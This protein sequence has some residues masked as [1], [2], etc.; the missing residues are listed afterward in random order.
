MGVGGTMRLL[1]ATT[2]ALVSAITASAQGGNAQSEIPDSVPV[3]DDVGEAAPSTW[4]EVQFERTTIRLPPGFVPSGRI[5]GLDHGG[6][7]WVRQSV[8]VRAING[9]WAFRSFEASAGTRCV[10]ERQGGQVLLIER[11]SRDGL[12]A[13]AWYPYPGLFPIFQASSSRSED[14]QLIRQ[15]LLS[16]S[17]SSA[18]APTRIRDVAKLIE[19]RTN[20]SETFPVFNYQ[21]LFVLGDVSLQDYNDATGVVRRELRVGEE[22]IEVIASQQLPLERKY[23]KDLIVRT[24][25][26]PCGKAVKTP[27]GT[28]IP[29]GGNSGRELVFERVADRLRL[30]VR[31][32]WID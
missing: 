27:D 28:T 1:L 8:S 2:L 29:V 7:E 17:P 31:I 13:T 25:V 14:L 4:R 15:I 11:V 21:G 26:G 18:Q 10:T 3:C 19:M 20:L 24:C 5:V 32:D 23:G 22:I 9:Y 30:S 12:V 16:A 6:V